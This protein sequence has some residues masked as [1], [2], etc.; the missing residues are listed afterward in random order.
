MYSRE[1][2]GGLLP[3]ASALAEGILFVANKDQQRGITKIH[4]IDVTNGKDL[5]FHMWEGD[6]LS[7][8]LVANGVLYFLGD[9]H[10]FALGTEEGNV[11]WEYDF[12]KGASDGIAWSMAAA[13]G[14]LYV[15][16]TSLAAPNKGYL[17]ALGVPD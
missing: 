13:D 3:N 6:F 14:K 10:L 1:F 15:A 17:Y 5:W 16:Y 7:D 4:A 9:D 8:L 2:S 11:L 12:S